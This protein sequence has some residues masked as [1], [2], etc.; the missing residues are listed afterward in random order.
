MSMIELALKAKVPL[1]AVKTTDMVHVQEV[2]SWMAGEQV[3]PYQGANPGTA[4]TAQDLAKSNVFYTNGEA[5]AQTWM[6][7]KSEGKT[8]VFVNTKTSALHL[9][10]GSMFPPKEM[11][12]SYLGDWME[13]FGVH[14]LEAVKVADEILPA[15]GGLTLK[16]AFEVVKLTREKHHAMTAKAVNNVRQGLVSKAKGITQVEVDA[17]FYQAPQYLE[18]WMELNAKFFLNPPHPTLMPRGLLFDGPPGTG[19]TAGAK[20]VASQFGIPLYHLDIGAMKGKYVGDSEGALMG[21]LAQIDQAAPCVVIFDEVEKGFNVQGDKGVTSS[22]LGQ[23]LWWLQEHKTQVFTVMTTNDK[24][25]IPPELFREGRIDS[26]MV[27]MGLET[28]EEGMDFTT[29][30]YENLASKVG[31]TSTHGVMSK[32]LA[33]VKTQLMNGPIPQASAAEMV[34]KLVKLQLNAKGD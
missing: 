6:R 23:L 20:Y 27:F 2:L 1:I 16:E 5:D 26:S 14:T 24:T 30:V 10:C 21:A 7:M 28:V 29:K 9:D 31:L 18:S 33:Y 32:L 4:V 34:N 15:F 25:M 19:K 3:R 22:M 12:R 17:E 8:L 11:L 13:E